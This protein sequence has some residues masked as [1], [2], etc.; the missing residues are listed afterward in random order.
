MLIKYYKIIVLNLIVVKII[1]V[2]FMIFYRYFLLAK[3]LLQQLLKE[4]CVR[5]NL[6]SKASK[7]PIVYH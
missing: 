7:M 5:R 6:F 2:G 4:K 3:K 1:K